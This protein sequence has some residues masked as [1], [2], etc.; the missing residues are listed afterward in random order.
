[1]ITAAGKASRSGSGVDTDFPRVISGCCM[2]YFVAVIN[3]S[4]TLASYS[5]YG[6]SSVHVAALGVNMLNTN[7]NFAAYGKG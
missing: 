2:Y 6:N 5:N 3:N 7:F 4:D 1:L